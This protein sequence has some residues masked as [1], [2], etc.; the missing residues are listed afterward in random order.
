MYHLILFTS[1]ILYPV[2][3]N[4]AKVAPR[5]TTCSEIKV[6]VDLHVEDRI[7]IYKVLVERRLQRVDD[8]RIFQPLL[9]LG[10]L[11]GIK[12][13]TLDIVSNQYFAKLEHLQHRACRVVGDR[14]TFKHI[15]GARNFPSEPALA[16]GRVY[17]K[18]IRQ[19]T[20]FTAAAVIIILDTF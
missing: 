3:V 8:V 5:D 7:K 16:E 14:V 1:A 18:Y 15:F 19:M 20:H 17:A 10:R 6:L 11:Y 4:I 2:E 13:D 9:Q 12:D